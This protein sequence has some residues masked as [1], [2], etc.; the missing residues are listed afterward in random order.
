MSSQ[1]TITRLVLQKRDPNRVSVFLDEAFAFGLNKETVLA[2][3]LRKG[4]FLSEAR[5]AEIQLADAFIAAKQAALQLISRRMQTTKELRSKLLRKEFPEMVV[6]K[7]V[8]WATVQRFLDDAL[9][10]KLFVEARFQ[11]KKH[12]AARIRMDLLKRGVP[13]PLIDKALAENLERD[14]VLETALLLAEKQW[15]KL[16]RE[17][18]FMKRKKKLWDFLLRRGYLGDVV[19]QVVQAIVK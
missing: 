12:G 2:Q 1:G 8:E 9:F 3:G 15:A 4:V 17:P 16:Q 11:I 18:D 19:R 14:D 13:K 5:I 6:E 10:A 7:V